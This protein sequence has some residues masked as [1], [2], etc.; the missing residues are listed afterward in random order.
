MLWRKIESKAIFIVLRKRRKGA[1]PVRDARRTH[2]NAP[3]TGEKFPDATPRP[4]RRT[5]EKHLY[6][7]PAR[8]QAARKTL[9]M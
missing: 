9:K 4:P 8:L 3:E 1:R 7:P 6:A 2:K 5:A